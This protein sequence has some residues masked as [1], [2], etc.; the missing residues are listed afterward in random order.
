MRDYLH[1]CNYDNEDTFTLYNV[2]SNDAI[3]E[4]RVA[5]K[6]HLKSRYFNYYRNMD[7]VE[8]YNKVGL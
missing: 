7:S 6:P 4:D 8:A 3:A 1:M 2:R 5:E